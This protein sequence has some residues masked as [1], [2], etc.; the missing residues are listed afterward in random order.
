MSPKSDTPSLTFKPTLKWFGLVPVFIVFFVVSQTFMFE[1]IFESKGFVEQPVSKTYQYDAKSKDLS[2]EIHENL[3]KGNKQLEALTS[4]LSSLSFA[5]ES[6][7]SKSDQEKEIQRLQEL[8]ANLQADFEDPM[9][10]KRPS[11]LPG[12]PEK[13]LSLEELMICNEEINIVM[14]G[15]W[16][17][18]SDTSCKSCF[19]DV[20]KRYEDLLAAFDAPEVKAMRMASYKEFFGP[21]KNKDIVISAVNSGQIYLFLNWVCSCEKINLDPRPFTVVVPTDKEAADVLRNLNFHIVEPDW[22]DSLAKP[23][24]S[25]YTGLANTG[26]HADINNIV[27]FV[28]TEVLSELGHNVLL[29]D[30]DIAWTGNV[31]EFLR[32]AGSRRDILAM[33]A[34]YYV[35]KGGANTGFLYARASR[36]NTIFF[37]T[38]KIAAAVKKTSDQELVNILLR[39]RAF[40]QIS[41]RYLPQ[42]L[43]YK[44]SGRRAKAPTK[45]MLM[46]HAVGSHKRT[47]FLRHDM[48]T[49]TEQCSVYDKDID[50]KS[51]E[52]VNEGTTV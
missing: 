12:F 10:D 21:E 15:H 39:H 3:V 32:K 22:L 43:F 49:F 7:I 29:H 9:D 48:W 51:I 8:A 45:E 47:S 37:Q 42:H 52:A 11:M 40:Q 2:M 31:M 35:A 30:V 46:Y 26:G 41:Y 4:K 19:S 36:K 13:P 1:N 27:L 17:C 25:K 20:I 23:I 24:S 33:F 34:P 38:L 44:Y 28:A 5:V 6:R 16:K 50:L 18:A 14:K